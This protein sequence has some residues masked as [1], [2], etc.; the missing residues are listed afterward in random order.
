MKHFDGFKV[1]YPNGL[2]FVNPPY[3]LAKPALRHALLEFFAGASSILLLPTQTCSNDFQLALYLRQVG[4]LFLLE[5]ITF[6]MHAA[7]LLRPL[8]LVYL[9]Q[10][11]FLAHFR[12]GRINTIEDN[13]PMRL[14]VSE[15]LKPNPDPKVL[16]EVQ[17]HDSDKCTVKTLI[18]QKKSRNELVTE[19]TVVADLAPRKRL[20]KA[21]FKAKAK[22]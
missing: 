8:S 2:T 22:C 6:G 18:A 4:H 11:I 9:L 3:S 14:L 12:V 21:D 15:L 17:M 7:P 19:D 10:P 5:P 20:I 1:P 16:A 13:L